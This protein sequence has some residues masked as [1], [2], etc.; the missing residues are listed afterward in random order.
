VA[1]LA[2][3]MGGS[4]TVLIHIT[5]SYTLKRWKRSKTHAK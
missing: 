3:Q 5:K 1:L 4:F 2:V